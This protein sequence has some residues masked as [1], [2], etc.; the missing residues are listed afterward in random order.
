[1]LMDIACFM[2]LCHTVCQFLQVH[3]APDCL[4]GIRIGGLDPDLKLNKPRSECLQQFKILL[5]QK[6]TADLKVKVGNTIIMLSNI[7]PDLIGIIPVAVECTVHKLYLRHL[8]LNKKVQFFLRLFHT[9]DP[10][11]TLDRGKTVTARK[12]AATDAL[13]IQDLILQP[14]Q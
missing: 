14:I 2:H 8:S 3:G 13:I 7:S 5:P 9:L 12:R 6:I 1:M 11:G 4:N 10:D